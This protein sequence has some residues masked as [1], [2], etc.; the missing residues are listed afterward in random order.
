MNYV[1]KL[2]KIDQNGAMTEYAPAFNAQPLDLCFNTAD[3][4][5][6][7]TCSDGTATDYIAKVSTAGAI[8]NQFAVSGT[9]GLRQISA[10]AGGDL[11]LIAKYADEDEGSFD[12]QGAVIKCTTSGSISSHTN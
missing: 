1:P 9:P 8:L 3:N 11:F 10:D 5:L 6:Y 7:I 2:V 12:P 4:N